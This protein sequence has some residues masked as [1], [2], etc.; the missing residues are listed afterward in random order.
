MDSNIRRKHGVGKKILIGA[1]ALVIVALAAV[2]VLQW[3]KLHK[4]PAAEDRRV[5][6]AASKIMVLP[7]E[8]ALVSEIEN[9]DKVKDQPFFANVENGD[10]VLIFI[11]AGKIV[12]FR[13]SENKIINAGPIVNDSGANAGSDANETPVTPD[14]SGDEAT[15][16]EE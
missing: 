3:F 12:I 2:V 15:D 14:L 16:D 13:Q 10:Q 4:D 11:K 9:A 5:Q 6:E 1:V 8:D 7:D